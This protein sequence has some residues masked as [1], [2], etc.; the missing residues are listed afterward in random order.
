ML[1]LAQSTLRALEESSQLEWL[2]TSG[3]GAFAMGTAAGMNT[4]RYHAHLVAALAPPVNRKVTLSRLEEALDGVELGVNTYPGAIHPRGHEHLTGFRL[5]PFPVWTWQVGDLRLEKR[6]FLVHGQSS[7]VVRYLA[8]APCT[9]TLHPLLA[10]RDVHALQHSN[11]QLDGAWDSGPGHFSLRPYAG[12]PALRFFHDG[13]ASPDGAGWYFATQYPVER[14]RGLDFEEDLWCAGTVRYALTAGA[15][16]F[17]AATLERDV[18]FTAAQLEVL[19]RLER[20]RRTPSPVPLATGKRPVVEQLT[21]AA[22]A[23]RARGADG[24]PTVLA[25]FPWFTEWGRD[26]M[27]CLP[28]LL[29]SRGLL[30]EASAVLR[31]FL[32]HLDRGLIPN[33][34]PDAGGRPEY[35]T[36]DATLWLFVAVHHLAAAGGD[37]EFLEDT[38]LPRLLE[39]LDWHERGTHHAIQVDPADGLLSAGSPGTQLTWMDAKVDDWVVT[40]R[41]GKAVELNALWFNALEIT[42]RL[43]AR[44]GLALEAQLFTA[45]AARVAN[46]FP[47]AFWNAQRRCLDDV[48]RPD[49]RDSSLRPNQLFAVSLPYCALNLE[50]QAAVVAS[51][52]AHLLTPFGLRTLAPREP[53]YQPRYGGDPRSRDGAYHQGTVWPWLLG[54]FVDATLRVRGRT[55]SALADCARLLAPLEQHLF[56]AGC[57]GQLPEVFDGDAPHRPG[58]T[59][60]QAWSVAELLRLRL[61]PLR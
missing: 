16:A 37:A 41:H 1:H 36:A 8:S 25:G 39:I 44:F 19:E 4:R 50:Q 38:V 34:F 9:L 57:L 54:P 53:G 12:L 26:S 42:A 45:K 29:I 31:H 52:Q 17:F 47:A 30:E 23:Y 11:P 33:R 60:A 2:D 5:D 20:D 21:L 55:P 59:P 61:G 3:S 58:G 51:A 10:L 7:V 22:D 14:D 48:L 35:N 40:P 18:T 24:L 6:L 27:I 28:G 13:E 56:Q 32:A 46:T 43:C 49:G 15:P